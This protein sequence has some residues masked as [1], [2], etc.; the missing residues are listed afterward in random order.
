MLIL[1][2]LFFWL[3]PEPGSVAGSI[4]RTANDR[5]RFR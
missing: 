1:Q 4:G 2:Q 3:A 5:D